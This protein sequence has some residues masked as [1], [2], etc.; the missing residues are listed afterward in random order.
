MACK[1]E[2]KLFPNFLSLDLSPNSLS[3]SL[4][5]S[6]SQFWAWDFMDESDEF[7]SYVTFFVLLLTRIATRHAT[8]I[9]LL[10][11]SPNAPRLKTPHA[12]VVTLSYLHFTPHV[13][14]LT[15]HAL[16]VLSPCC[17]SQLMLR[18]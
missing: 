1:I 9:G 10:H 17:T 15:P 7:E 11:T 13:S 16:G 18:C 4:S 12:L 2:S 14:C 5:L 3:L 8:T 6:L